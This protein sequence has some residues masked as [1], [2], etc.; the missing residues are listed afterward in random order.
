MS[1]G[2]VL[3]RASIV[4]V[5]AVLMHSGAAGLDAGSDWNVER[6]GIAR[7]RAGSRSAADELRLRELECLVSL[8]LDDKGRPTVPAAA[9]RAAV[10]AGARRL[11]Q[12][13]LVREGLRVVSVDGFGYDEGRYGCSLEELG[14]SAQFTAAVVV[15]RARILRTRAKFDMPWSLAFTVELNSEL[16]GHEEL[17]R[18]LEIAGDRVGLG[19]WRTEKPGTYGRFRLES[20][21][22]SSR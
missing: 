9:V 13:P 14:I 3:F 4:G 22:T 11:K 7:K 10:E 2:S 5:S 17:A 15:Q 18:W 6:T 19:D 12:G 8:W 1:D 16:A 21:E 20:I